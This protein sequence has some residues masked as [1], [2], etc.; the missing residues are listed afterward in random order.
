MDLTSTLSETATDIDI[1]STDRT[2]L[3][4]PNLHIILFREGKSDASRTEKKPLPHQNATTSKKMQSPSHF[5]Q[6]NS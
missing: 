3:T 6:E 5:Q 2:A 1:F 4:S